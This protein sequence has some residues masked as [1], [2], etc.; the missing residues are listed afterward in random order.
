MR[1]WQEKYLSFATVGAVVLTFFLPLG[2]STAHAE[3]SKTIDSHFYSLE[4]ANYVGEQKSSWI[5]SFKGEDALVLS[6]DIG[7]I[8]PEHEVQFFNAISGEFRPIGNLVYPGTPGT[9]FRT[10]DFVSNRYPTND[11]QASFFITFA[12]ATSDGSCRRVHVYQYDADLSFATKSDQISGSQIFATTCF[13][14]TSTGSYAVHQSGG[15]L[16]QIPKKD[17][18]SKSQEFYLSLG[19]FANTEINSRLSSVAK[20][21][22]SSV[23]RISKNGFTQ[24]ASGFRNPQGLALIYLNKREYLLESEHGA[25]GGDELN[26]VST[27]FYGW[28]SL[29][30]GTN[31]IKGGPDLKP[32]SEGIIGSSKIPLYAWLP[33]VAP[34]Q[35][36]QLKG[37]EFSKWWKND[38]KGVYEGDIVVSTLAGKSLQRLRV[39]GGA[40]RYC[41]TIPVGERIRS[42]SETSS[43]K[44]LLGTDSG[45]ILVI[46][47]STEW[48]SNS[49]DFKLV[50]R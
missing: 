31:Y 33:S 22:I 44:L 34:S 39:I 9:I 3:N 13:P 43:G 26:L 20:K 47:A 42:I 2:A 32:K 41:E 25:R 16:V 38:W 36:L 37:P 17:W 28:P 48:D 40:V 46:S 19:D 45:T 50:T 23:L 18:K 27:G 11:S 5:T 6:S 24:I 35:L 1:I 4:I 49:S 30:L 8:Y 29:T 7:N 15:R 10:L 12:S 21:Q 14:K